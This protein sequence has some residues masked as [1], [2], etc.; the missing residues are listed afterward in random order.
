MTSH[1]SL[2]PS[3]GCCKDEC[4]ARACPRVIG[5]ERQSGLSV[6][7]SPPPPPPQKTLSSLEKEAVQA[8]HN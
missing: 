8:Q 4:L 3:V 7:L 5:L 2:P 1:A 6:C